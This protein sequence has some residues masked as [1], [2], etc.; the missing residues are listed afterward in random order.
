MSACLLCQIVC[1][2]VFVVVFTHAFFLYLSLVSLSARDSVL[3]YAVYQLDGYC[4]CPLCQRVS[5]H[6][7]QLCA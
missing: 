6:V 2:G 3:P 4:A 5:L 1:P 7:C